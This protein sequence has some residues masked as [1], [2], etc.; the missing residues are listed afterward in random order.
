[1]GP[2]EGHRIIEI[3][4]IG[5]GPYCA[6][7]LAD[8]GAEVVRVVRPGHV[9]LVKGFAL[10]L[11]NRNRRSIYLDLKHGQAV[12]ALLRMVERADG[13]IEG[14]RP[15]VM[16]R[17]GLGPEICLERN[18]RLVYGRMTG[19]GQ[20]GPLAQTAGHD[21]N[22]IALAGVLAHIGRCGGPP[23]PPL[24]LVAD[25]GG[26]GL[27]LAFGMVCALLERLRSHRGQVVD[28]AMVDGANSLMTLMHGAQHAGFWHEERGTNLLDG[29]APFYDVYE[30]AD[31][32]YVSIGAI[33]PQFYA[34]LLKLTGLDREE[35]PPQFDREGWPV[36]RE[37]LTQVFRSRTRD[38]WCEIMEGTDACFAPV[39]SMTEARDHP[40]NR[41]RGAFVELEGIPQPRPAPRFSRTDARLRRP[42]A[43]AG[44]HTAEVLADWGF[45][46]REIA[47][48]RALKAAP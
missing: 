12:A 43:P 31:G 36:I 34:Q 48:L 45:S 22:Y 37:R 1:M 6:M 16:E 46:E 14:F 9:P 10:D 7:L 44:A 20:D 29:G 42:P 26:G 19:Y 28:A 38:E 40:H 11:L 24:N 41:A 32:G 13:L 30:T 4:G 25:F 15:G 2:L 23:V 35:L 33:E 47:E 39:L 17:L 27:L 18:P 3:A 8:M 21:I 5:P